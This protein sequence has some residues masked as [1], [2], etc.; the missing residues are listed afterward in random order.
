MRPPCPLAA[1][2]CL[3]LS[4]LTGCV[5]PENL[6][7]NLTDALTRPSAP[8]VDTGDAGTTGDTG[9]ASTTGDL[10]S[11]SS[12]SSSGVTTGAEADGD[13]AASFFPGG[14]DLLIVRT[15]D[16]A[17][18]TCIAVYFERSGGIGYFEDTVEL[19][20]NWSV[21][22][23]WLYPGAVDCLIPEG[24]PN[25]PMPVMALDAAG[26]ATWTTGF[27]PGPVDIDM[28]VSFAQEEP[29]EPASVVMQATGVPVWGC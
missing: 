6:G 3:T 4:V 17:S 16:M 11:S 10:P 14:G 20:V 13:Y 29:W 15:I 25:D 28:T 7:D 24:P 5:V 19:P 27:C 1:L 9:D 12:G 21:Q 23:I 26:E 22:G 18:G 2:P 8:G